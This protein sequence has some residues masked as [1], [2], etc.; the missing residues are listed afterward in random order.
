MKRYLVN[1]LGSVF[2]CHTQLSPSFLE[3]SEDN[4]ELNLLRLTQRP[5]EGTFKPQILLQALNG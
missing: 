2:L 5:L 3:E 1:Y 4:N